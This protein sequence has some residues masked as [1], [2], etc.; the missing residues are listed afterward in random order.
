[1][2]TMYRSQ[3]TSLFLG[4]VANSRELT[5]IHQEMDP[6]ISFDEF[7]QKVHNLQP[8]EFMSLHNIGGRIYLLDA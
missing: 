8:Y 6:G 5:M 4:F 2:S 7:K 1:M 3:L